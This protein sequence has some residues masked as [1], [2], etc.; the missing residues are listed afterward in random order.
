MALK[1]CFKRDTVGLNS[2]LSEE[3]AFCRSSASLSAAV[4]ASFGPWWWWGWGWG[5]PACRAGV[6]GSQVGDPLSV[7]NDDNL[8]G[9]CTNSGGL[10]GIVN[11]YGGVYATSS[12]IGMILQYGLPARNLAQ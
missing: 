1:S 7:G 3:A 5:W 4:A 12:G 11:F 8:L 10:L 9:P 2:P 6:P